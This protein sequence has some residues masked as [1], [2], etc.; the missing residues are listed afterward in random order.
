M[1]SD[2][3]KGLVL[4]AIDNYVDEHGDHPAHLV[5]M[6]RQLAHEI[7]AINEKLAR[8]EG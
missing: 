1:S 2:A 4:Q 8:G 5:E 7:D 6:L 3:V